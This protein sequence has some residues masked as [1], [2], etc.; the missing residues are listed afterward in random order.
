MVEAG[1]YPIKTVIKVESTEGAAEGGQIP[2]EMK[3]MMGITD[4]AIGEDGMMTVFSLA[5]E[6]QSIEKKSIDDSKF[7]I[8]EGF[9]KK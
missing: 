4:E 1:G 8:P 7:E 6:V 3:A 9:E 5:S 2:P